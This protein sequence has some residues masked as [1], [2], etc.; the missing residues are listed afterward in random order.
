MLLK[1]DVFFVFG[2]TIQFLVLVIQVSDPEFA[3]TI[4]AMPIIVAVLALAVY[5]ARRE[6]RMIM[7]M[8]I[9]GTIAAITYFLFKLVRI[10]TVSLP[11]YQ[12][13]RNYLTLFSN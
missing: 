13:T 10:W 4:A 7:L 12:D 9:L 8:F 5:G 1:L 6:D 2:F 3:I 11:Q